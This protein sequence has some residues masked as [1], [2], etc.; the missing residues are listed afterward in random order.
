MLL[1]QEYKKN[2]FT[3]IELVIAIA[4]IVLV[5][6]A[7]TSAF[8]N[9]LNNTKIESVKLDTMSDVQAIIQTLKLQGKYGVD[10]I[11]N[12]L[13]TPTQKS[14]S[15]AITIDIK[16]D[17]IAKV[18]GVAG[19]INLPEYTDR[20]DDSDIGGLG[21]Q[22]NIGTHYDVKITIAPEA[23]YARTSY[24]KFNYFNIYLIKV[25]V[26]DLNNDSAESEASAY[27]GG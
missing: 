9:A 11:Y 23:Y 2:G 20:L 26:N 7:I 14:N 25:N 21:L 8:I 16:Y 1:N 10:K 18:T 27:I 24:T 13:A 19:K 22:N 12:N 3:L 17:D 6:P 4:I 5:I 15:S